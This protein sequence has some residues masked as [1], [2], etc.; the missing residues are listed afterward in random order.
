MSKFVAYNKN[1]ELLAFYSKDVHG[2]NIPDK[3]IFI[4]DEK[5]QEILSKGKQNFR[6]DLNSNEVV[7]YN[8]PIVESLEKKYNKKIVQ[9]KPKTKRIIEKQYPLW[10]QQNLTND[11]EIAKFSIQQLYNAAGI[12][13]TIEDIMADITSLFS[14]VQMYDAFTEIENNIEIY[15]L[16]DIVEESG[17]P[18]ID[19]KIDKY[20]RDI[21]KGYV[22]YRKIQLLREWSNLE[23]SRITDIYEDPNK[24]PEQK[25]EE[26]ENYVVKCHYVKEES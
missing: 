7:P 14:N 12:T 24:S 25:L 19:S 23:E 3:V 8:P 9:I 20:Y 17:D 16:S 26:L 6:V 2:E 21:I 1:T 15:D 4:T 11:S 5:W 18:D 22:A 10:K 13:K